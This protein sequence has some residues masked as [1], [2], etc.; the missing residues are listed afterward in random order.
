MT[1]IIT[2]LLRFIPEHILPDATRIHIHDVTLHRDR[3]PALEAREYH[4]VVQLSNLYRT[5]A[6]SDWP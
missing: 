4:N 2:F 3:P 1:L 6:A 5:C